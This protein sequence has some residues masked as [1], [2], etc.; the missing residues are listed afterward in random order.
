MMNCPNCGKE[1]AAEAEYCVQCGAYI[2]AQQTMISTPPGEAAPAVY[3]STE[4][5]KIPFYKQKWGIGLIIGLTASILLCCLAGAIAGIYVYKNKAS[6]NDYQ[7]Q[8]K[9]SYDELQ[10]GANE[11]DSAIK[12]ADSGGDLTSLTQEIEDQEDLTKETSSKLESLEVSEKD[13]DSHEKFVRALD[14]YKD[15]LDKLGTLSA[16]PLNL[17]LSAEVSKIS[18]VTQDTAAVFEDF[19]DASPFIEGGSGRLVAKSSD[20]TSMLERMRKNLALADIEAKPNPFSP[21]GDGKDDSATIYFDVPKSAIITVKI[22]DTAGTEIKTLLDRQEVSAIQQQVNWLG[23]DSLG[24]ILSNGTYNYKITAEF[25]STTMTEDGTLTIEGVAVVCATCGGSGS[26][27]C[28][29]C[30]GDGGAS[31]SNCGA[32]G[33]VSCSDCEGSG[34]CASCG[35]TG[36]IITELGYFVCED[37]DGTGRCPTCGGTAGVDCSKCGGDGQVSCSGCGGDGKVTCSTCGGDGTI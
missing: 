34:N 20:I 37:C 26:V 11:I 23:D 12:K 21:N 18:D 28:A 8:A 16:S 31:C 24:A 25:D 6:G 36:E 35:G 2:G 7:S 30:G 5:P 1:L 10:V 33:W 17:D 15:Y 13:K 22:L 9:N 19:V 4:A 32:R 3:P 14:A 27:T 29:T